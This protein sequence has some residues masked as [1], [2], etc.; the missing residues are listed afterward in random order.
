MMMGLILP[1]VCLAVLR[2]ILLCISFTVPHNVQLR[3]YL[4]VV[5]EVSHDNIMVTFLSFMFFSSYS[6]MLFFVLFESL[7]KNLIHLIFCISVRLFRMDLIQK[8][9]FLFDEM[10]KSLPYAYIAVKKS[11]HSYRFPVSM[12]L[13]FL[14]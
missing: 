12:F 11:L 1:F 10:L 9:L 4:N 5:T 7:K 2:Q 3:S 6:V 13:F 14:T 8:I